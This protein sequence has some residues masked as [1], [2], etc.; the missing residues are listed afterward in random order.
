MLISLALT[1]AELGRMRAAFTLLDLA[2][3]IG[4]PEDRAALAQQR[5]LLLIL[6]GRMDAALHQLDRAIALLDRGVDGFKLAAALLNRGLLHHNTGRI[7]PAE[8][9]LARCEQVATPLGQPLLV[10]KVIHNR[11]HCDLLRGDIPSALRRFESAAEHYRRGGADPLLGMVSMD[12]G[13]ALLAAGLANEAA[14][15]LSAAATLLG[16][17]CPGRDRAEVDLTSAQ[18]AL[19]T[20]DWDQ[21]RRCAG[22]AQRRF[23]RDGN[24]AWAKVAV[25]AGLWARFR[26]C[27]RPGDRRRLGAVAG[28]ANR[29][30]TELDALGLGA[31]A[32]SARLLAVRA[33]RAAGH[34]ERAAAQLP[35]RRR[36]LSI[37]NQVQLRLAMA[38]LHADRGEHGAV[39]R[40]CRIGLTALDRHRDQLGS[41]DLRTGS[42][43]LG[44]E[45][46]AAG[47]ASALAGG[48]AARVFAWLERCRAQSFRGIPVRPPADDD[49][50]DA[51]AELRYLAGQVRAAELT[52]ERALAQRRR[53]GQLERM[54]RAKGWSVTGQT[55]SESSARFRDVAEELHRCGTV[56]VSF[57][58]HRDQLF[59]LTVSG[60]RAAMTHL[61]EWNT[62]GEAVTRLHGDLDALCALALPATL[63]TVVRAS[64]R[65]QANLLDQLLLAPLRPTLRDRDLVIVPTRTLSAVPWAVLPALHGRPV[66]VSPSASVWLRG[67]RTPAPPRTS[68]PLLVGG[69]DLPHAGPEVRAIA[70]VH[71]DATLVDGDRAT[72]QTVLNLMCGRGLVHIAA[73]G[74]HERDNVLFSRLDLVDGPLMAH[75][76]HQLDQPPEHVVLPA[77][78]VGRTVV[79]TGDELLGFTA[80]LLY[81]GTRTV[82]SCVNRVLDH[83]AM[84]AMPAYHR[85]L[86]TGIPPARALADA[87]APDPLTPFVCFGTG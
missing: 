13:R 87:C 56:L 11:G 45:L 77:C 19:N 54:I 73:H 70:Q 15:E 60:E 74:H 52:G 48:S 58:V 42:A 28:Q 34:G 9:D 79:R 65:Y 59:A 67:R 40:H 1:Q 76:V 85:A 75:D 35:A 39:L 84:L 50:A 68:A 53:C 32:D 41:L 81:S 80:A 17:R 43:A 7:R 23:H 26:R 3:A 8:A 5:G 69:P 18:I 64:A 22:R 47:L 2:E 27:L 49:L 33:H 36:N 20:G 82:I 86:V 4:A 16:P 62:I 72:V 29:L 12:R 71:P 31:D 30:G 24:E 10:A 55:A 38:E 6:S 63:D 57:L 46:A 44:D 14:I 78:D 61:S 51:V 66:T 25:L 37:G 21:A 83:E